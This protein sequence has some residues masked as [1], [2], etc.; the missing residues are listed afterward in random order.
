MIGLRFNEFDL[1][2]KYMKRL[3]QIDEGKNYRNKVKNRSGKMI[4]K[5][6][7]MGDLS[8]KDDDYLK[9][10][11]FQKK[12]FEFRNLYEVLSSNHD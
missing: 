8:L 10:E 11:D 3:K 1:K 2:N 4:K 9:L 12:A 6:K 7:E 5:L